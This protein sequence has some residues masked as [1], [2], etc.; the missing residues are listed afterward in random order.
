MRCFG[1]ILELECI[2][3]DHPVIQISKFKTQRG[4]T[5]VERYLPA[6]WALNLREERATLTSMD[7]FV[8]DLDQHGL[9][10]KVGSTSSWLCDREKHQT[11]SEFIVSTHSNVI[12][13]SQR[14]GQVVCENNTE[15][16][17]L[18]GLG[19]AG[20]H[21]RTLYFTLS[22]CMTLRKWLIS[23]YLSFLIQKLR[24]VFLIL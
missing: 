19:L 15:T 9:V 22:T 16:T 18:D 24:I 1:V 17:R 2:L 14:P 10:P 8:K 6:H 23:F 11:F 21:K 20:S 7:Y 4:W 5:I 3:A 13:F 12:R